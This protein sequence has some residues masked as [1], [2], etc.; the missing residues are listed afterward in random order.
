[1]PA[2]SRQFTKRRA[3]ALA[4]AQDAVQSERFRLLV[5]GIAAW[6]EVGQW[7]EPSDGLTGDRG[8]LPIEIF[9]AEQLSRRR[10][11]L[12]KGRKRFAALDS[13]RRHKLRIQAKKLRYADD[14]F[15]SLFA[16]RQRDKRR[17][18]F[19]A[20]LKRVQNSLG[21]VN[22]V[23]VHEKIISA[24]DAK[25]ARASRGKTFAAGLLTGRED[26]RFNTAM[27]AAEKALR[28]FARAKP[29]WT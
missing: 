15:S 7:T 24:A 19:G 1:V 12:R 28:Q 29:F 13:R 20:A 22:D 16:G 26:A 25:R 27:A 23:G 2:L 18:E 4:R 11:K 14:F 3:E 5:L 6:L 9:A 8:E 10:R 17:A 21:D